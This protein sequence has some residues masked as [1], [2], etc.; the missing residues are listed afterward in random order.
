MTQTIKGIRDLIVAKLETIKDTEGN[1]IFGDIFG[2][3]KGDFENYP[4][5]VVTPSGGKGEVLD[6]HRNER[7]FQFT[8]KL[9]QE[10]SRAGKTPE[11]ADEMM[12][13]ASD[14]ILKAFDVDEDLGGEVQIVRVV[15][16]DTDFKVAAGTFNFA[17]F[18]V[19]CVV[20]VLD[21]E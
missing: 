15:E 21:Y 6:T 11:E 5:V 1:D 3:A 19:D 18:R 12:T 7:T 20:I 17:T 4:V 13:E 10:Q 9:Y 14:A 16:F 8:I 2:Y